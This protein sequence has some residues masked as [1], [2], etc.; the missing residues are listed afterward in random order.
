MQ[1]FYHP[2]FQKNYQKI[3]LGIK[4]KAERKEIIFRNNPLDPRL[5]THKLH[6]KLK[7]KLSFSIDD[8]YRII[9]EFDNSDV[10][11]LDIGNH[12]LY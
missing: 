1:I 4:I 11:F 8:K 9:F 2:R 5:K 12:K 7:N 10:I 6:S 3:P